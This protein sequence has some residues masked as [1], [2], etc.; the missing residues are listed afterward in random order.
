V[1]ES[2][3]VVDV[4]TRAGVSLG[5]V[6]NVLNHPDRVAPATRDRVMQAIQELGF[7]RNE[8]ARQLRAGRSRTIGLVVLDVGNPFFTEELT[9]ARAARIMAAMLA[10]GFTTV[11]DCCGADYGLALAVEEGRHRLSRA[12]AADRERGEAD[13]RQ[14]LREAADGALELR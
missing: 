5:T 3:S 6:S 1:S 7:V 14:K 13:Q 2:V 9:A 11:R 8:A 10:R 12:D 4:A